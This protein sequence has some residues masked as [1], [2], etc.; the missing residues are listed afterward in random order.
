VLIEN[1]KS[2]GAI[3]GFFF[4]SDDHPLDVMLGLVPSICYVEI[5]ET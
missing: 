2:P 4:L 1:E 5:L 3:R